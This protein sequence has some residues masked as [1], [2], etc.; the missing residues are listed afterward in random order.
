MEKHPERMAACRAKWDARNKPR[1][2]AKTRRYQAR[3][4]K[5]LPRWASKIK[6]NDFYVLAAQKT[7]ETGVPH[8]VDHIVPLTSAIVCGLHCEFNLRVI[9]MRDNRV[10]AARLDFIDLA[11]EVNEPVTDYSSQL[12]LQQA[13]SPER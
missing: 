9:P 5:A 6:M 3:K 11:A 1:V 8:E 12:R 2:L 10:K 13:T 7:S 4:R